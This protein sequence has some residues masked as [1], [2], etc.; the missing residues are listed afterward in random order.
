MSKM[1][2]ALDRRDRERQAKKNEIVELN[3]QLASSEKKN[4]TIQTHIGQTDIDITQHPE[5]QKLLDQIS[6]FM[7]DIE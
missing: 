2:S 5:Y 6:K 7:E 4:H 3:F 1:K